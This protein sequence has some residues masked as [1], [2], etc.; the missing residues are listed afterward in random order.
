MK[1]KLL[2]PLLITVIGI[3]ASYGQSIIV[4]TDP[5]NGPTN[6]INCNLF[7]NG[8]I[9][10]FFDS[11]G[12][13]ANYGNNENQVIT[14]C[15]DLLNGSKMSCSFGIN[16]G[17]S[18][19]VAGGDTLFVYDGPTTSAPLLGTHNSVTD[20]NGFFHTASFGNTTG[21]LTFK[22]VSNATVSSGGWAAN[23]TCGNPPQPFSP[24]IQAFI[25]GT[26][27]NILT[28][29][30]TGYANICFNDSI[31]FEASGTFPYAPVPPATH[32]GYVQ[33]TSNCTYLWKFSNG[34]Q[35]T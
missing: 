31:L 21:C 34:V 8:S 22:F 11:G 35:K 5:D 6:P 13:G 12:A 4:I 33:D 2:F 32:P 28:P 16:A 9:A 7:N 17:F 3:T 19:S 1:K 23:I 25:N 14:I 18:W 24:H 26:G 29:A 10:N 30:D 27:V 20:P 15:P